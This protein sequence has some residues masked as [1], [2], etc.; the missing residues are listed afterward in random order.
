M[1]PPNS[2]PPNRH[3]R[4]RQIPRSRPPR[5][6]EIQ[7]QI[8]HRSNSLLHPTEMV[9]TWTKITGKKVTFVQIPSGTS[10]SSL[11]PA[12]MAMV[13]ESAGLITEYSYYGPTGM[14]DLEWTLAQMEDAPGSWE[15]F[16]QANEPWFDG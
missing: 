12:M 9:S 16:V 7:P 3:H 15:D 4:H 6:R 10:S 13:K 11:P 2:D 1:V 8:P 14:K 5:P